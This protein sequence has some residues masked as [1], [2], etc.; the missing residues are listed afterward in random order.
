MTIRRR[1][2]LPLILFAFLS[3]SC[4]ASVSGSKNIRCG[5]SDAQQ[6]YLYYSPDPKAFLPVIV[7]LHG[8]G[9]HPENMLVAWKDLATTQRITLLA[10]ELPRDP[11]FEDAAPAVFRCVVEDAADFVHVDPW[12]VYL[13]GNSMG[14]YL[15]FDGAMFQSQYFAAIAVHANRIDEEY[16]GIVKQATRKMPIAIYIGDHD[17]FF[18]VESVRKTR[19]LLLKEGFPVHYVEL[20]HHD[21][22]YYARAEEINVDAWRFLQEQSLPATK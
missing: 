11:K 14:G 21:H 16:A 7:L 19:D 20:D 2:F 22:N 8:A 9:D 15:A 4:F 3:C 10:P 17:Q 1:I 18:P 5:H 12:R 6:K 13:F